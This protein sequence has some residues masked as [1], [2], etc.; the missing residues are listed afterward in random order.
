ALA[1]NSVRAPILDEANSTTIY[2]SDGTVL[3]HL[4]SRR[5]QALRGNQFADVVARVDPTST[6]TGDHG[7]AGLIVPHVLAE[8]AA[9]PPWQNM[10]FS[11]LAAAGLKI[12]T[13]IEP[14]A[15][16]L[17]E[18]VLDATAAGSVMSGQPVALEAAAV[19]VEPRT[20]RVLAYYGGR[21]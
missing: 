20:G 5:A 17:L 2:Y 14:S 1:G 9:L 19:V 3:A 13:T 6:P 7:P 21:D 10:S 18:R 8:V 11:Q 16:H 15:Q 12:Y 4:S